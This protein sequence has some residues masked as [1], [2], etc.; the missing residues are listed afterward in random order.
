MKDWKT[1]S[2]GVLL[3]VGAIVAIIFSVISGTITQVE[4]MTAA[5]A[6]LAGIGLLFAKDA[7]DDT[8]VNA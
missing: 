4:I 8:D 5:T 3:I 6:I 2:S 7:D 1:T